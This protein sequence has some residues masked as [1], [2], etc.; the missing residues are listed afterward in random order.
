MMSE[1][2]SDSRNASLNTLP[3]TPP[4]SI[5]SSDQ[6]G[7]D[8]SYLLQFLSN[9]NNETAIASLIGLAIATYFVFGRLGLLLIGIILGVVLHASWEIK[10]CNNTTQLKLQKRKQLKRTGL[11]VVDS[12]LQWRAEVNDIQQGHQAGN[13]NYENN[14]DVGNLNALPKTA[15]AIELLKDAILQNYVT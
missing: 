15:G 13:T 7:N 1:R 10:E 8:A 3:Q 12:L 5:D 4:V 11:E 6:S 14:Y 2:E 9:A